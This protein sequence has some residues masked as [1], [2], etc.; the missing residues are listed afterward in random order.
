MCSETSTISKSEFSTD[1]IFSKHLNEYRKHNV[2]LPKGFDKEN[3][4][5]IIYATDGNSS[6]T[7]KKN[8]LCWILLEIIR[9][10]SVFK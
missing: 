9:A 2:Y 10:S 6:L 5:P 7:E 1:S 4:Y 8:L 3:E